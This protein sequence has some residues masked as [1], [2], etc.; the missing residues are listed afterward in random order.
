MSFQLCRH[1]SYS[2]M[3]RIHTYVCLSVCLPVCLPACLFVCLSVCSH[4]ICFRFSSFH[5][6]ASYVKSKGFLLY[7]THWGQVTF[8]YTLEMCLSTCIGL[9]DMWILQAHICEVEHHTPT[10]EIHKRLH[11]NYVADRRYEHTVT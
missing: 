4:V 7:V 9:L 2:A 11:M 3:S 10:N 5:L 8:T 6:I 1:F